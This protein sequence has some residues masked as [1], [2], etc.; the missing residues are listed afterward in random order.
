MRYVYLIVILLFVLNL[1]GQ[2]E[3]NTNIPVLEKD[4]VEVNSKLPPLQVGDYFITCWVSH[5]YD[6]YQIKAMKTDLNG[7]LLWNNYQII[8]ESDELI[9]DLELCKTS[10]NNFVLLFTSGNN[11]QCQKRNLNNQLVWEIQPINSSEYING[12]VS[13]DQN[14]G[15]FVYWVTPFQLSGLHLNNTGNNLFNNTPQDIYTDANALTEIKVKQMSDN[16]FIMIVDNSETNSFML[17][18]DSAGNIING[19]VSLQYGHIID[20]K[21]FQNTYLI[22]G[23]STESMSFVKK[24]DSNLNILATFSFIDSPLNNYSD[25]HDKIFSLFVDSDT[26]F[27]VIGNKKTSS[28][29]GQI[30]LQKVTAQ[31]QILYPEPGTIL[32][33]YTITNQQYPKFDLKAIQGNQGDY[34]LILN[35]P[36][37][38]STSNMKF[39][40]VFANLVIN[41]PANVSIANTITSITSF[42]KSNDILNLFF[43]Q[44]K[45]GIQHKLYQLPFNNNFNYTLPGSMII[46]YQIGKAYGDYWTRLSGT[47]LMIFWTDVFNDIR[48]QIVNPNGDLTYTEN[49]LVL[50]SP[51]KNS[52]TGHTNKVMDICVNEIGD[53]A[54]LIVVNDS[55]KV[56]VFNSDNEQMGNPYTNTLDARCNKQAYLMKSDDGFIAV[57]VRGVYST[58][59]KELMCQKIVN[60]LMQWDQ[61]ILLL[62]GDI[63]YQR[64][65]VS[66]FDNYIVI[67]DPSVRV[68]KITDNGSIFPEWPVDGILL[69]E[70]SYS[71]TVKAFP[72]PSGVLVTWLHGNFDID[73]TLHA[74]LISPAGNLMYP[75]E[76]IVL[77]EQTQ[78]I[79]CDLY[80]DNNELYF[81]NYDQ[82]I[83]L[84]KY[85]ITESGL[86]PL[87]DSQALAL[88]IGSYYD[89]WNDVSFVDCSLGCLVSYRKSFSDFYFDI[90]VRA[91]SDYGFI[92][93]ADTLYI[94]NLMPGKAFYPQMNKINEH[95]SYLTWAFGNDIQTDAF[96]TSNYNIYIQK[97]NS[98]GFTENS[99]QIEIPQK[100]SLNCYPNPFNPTTTVSF[101][102]PQDSKVKLGIYNIKGQQIKIIQNSFLLKGQY[103]LQWNGTDSN[104]K[105]VSSGVYFYRLETNDKQITRKMLLL[106]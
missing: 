43:Y 55:L 85:Q 36:V 77:L 79:Y 63:A 81:L 80:C 93:N 95:E 34:Y 31:G 9:T 73:W 38:I 27:T 13:P 101:T 30:Y 7:N 44:F 19:P 97:I 64:K 37:N 11:I 88:G 61:G 67:A 41:I 66:F 99:G 96:E 84:K 21:E 49:G 14:G 100:L 26:V 23:V 45:S 103:N 2:V 20:I 60:G 76:G 65:L 90:C 68:L 42:N 6:K 56:Y 58:D 89:M 82:N 94:N 54:F 18:L 70:N 32:T 33:S 78:T 106:K 53:K 87:W 3:W 51:F 39:I 15:V 24:V 62:E 4:N 83:F 35:E 86:I 92:D 12:A 105:P 22:S 16:N 52:L 29:N 104:N 46:D 75:E 47:N 10:D 8:F 1:F 69:T 98:E 5:L 57:W 40:H 91:V 102:I 28:T 72:T 74:Q 25:A 48:L 71:N 50:I 59:N 17:K